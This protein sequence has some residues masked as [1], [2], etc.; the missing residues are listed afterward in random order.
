MS[1][2]SCCRRAE[3]RIEGTD[4]LDS[5]GQLQVLL[6]SQARERHIV[7][8]TGHITRQAEEDT[9]GSPAGQAVDYE[10]D[11]FRHGVIAACTDRTR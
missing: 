4:D 11:P 5:R 6:V 1:S 7:P 9:L 2:G 3:E 8:E 10:Q